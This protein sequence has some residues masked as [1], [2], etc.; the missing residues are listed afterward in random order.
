MSLQTI[1][2][3]PVP[4]PEP[5]RQQTQT[6]NPGPTPN[7][8]HPRN[9]RIHRRS[10]G[11][12]DPQ[13]VHPSSSSAQGTYADPVIAAAIKQSNTAI[14]AGQIRPGFA[15]GDD[16]GSS[17]PPVGG[18]D[19]TMRGRGPV[20]PKGALSARSGAAPSISMERAPIPEAGAAGG[21]G[22]ERY[23]D[24]LGAGGVRGLLAANATAAAT[25]K[26]AA[27][28]AATA[29]KPAAA[30]PKAAASG[31]GAASAAAAVVIGLALNLA[32][33]VAVVA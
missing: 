4:S 17:L 8:P 11:T 25:A 29:P 19:A 6:P 13:G 10:V 2:Q 7:H 30:A 33:A 26:P 18:V 15:P 31:A 28:P 3:T 14:N 16:Y 23:G 21:G 27:A 5:L 32:L 24:G 22:L 9:P 20:A 1:D 12:F